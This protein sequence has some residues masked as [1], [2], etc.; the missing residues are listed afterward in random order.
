MATGYTYTYRWTDNHTTQ[1]K[2]ISV[3]TGLGMIA[4][5]PVG[6]SWYREQATLG[7]EA[8][9]IQYMDPLMTYLAAFTPALKYTFLTS[10]RFRPYIEA[11]AGLIWT[12]LRNRIPEKGSQFNF[13]LQAGMGLSYFL[14]PM[15]SINVSYRFQ[16]V[17]SAGIAEPNHGIEAGAILIRISMF[18]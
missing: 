4:T 18:F 14:R 2:G 16:H 15:T 17:S 5:N 10:A 1:L 13:N 9:F 8:L 3:V 12:D 7:G 6:A 11:G